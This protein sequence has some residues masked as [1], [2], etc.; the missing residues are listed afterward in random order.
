M[1]ALFMR[2]LCIRKYFMYEMFSFVILQRVM[3]REKGLG[4]VLDKPRSLLFQDGGENLCISLEDIGTGWKCKG[5]YQVSLPGS[6]L[7]IND[8]QIWEGK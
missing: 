2:D 1:K 8:W 5:S 7:F 3:S 4:K 6:I